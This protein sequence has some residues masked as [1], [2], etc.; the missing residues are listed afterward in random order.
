[1]LLFLEGSI[2]PNPAKN[3]IELKA[4]QIINFISLC[5]ISGKN[6]HID[7]NPKTYKI[8]FQNLDTGMYILKTV[9][10][11]GKQTNS[12]ILINNH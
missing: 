11:N 3:F 4:N 12:N 2:F 1:M 7:Y 10:E 8:S 9:F 5:D 6:I